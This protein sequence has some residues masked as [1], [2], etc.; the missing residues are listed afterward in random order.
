M[1]RP[2]NKVLEDPGTHNGSDKS[3]LLR[4]RKRS[5]MPYGKSIS[6]LLVDDEDEFRDTCAMW[7]TRNDHDVAEATF[8]AQL[9]LFDKL[10]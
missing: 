4:N 9:K 3:K 8:V 7:T 1:R 6:I 5:E 10:D 2:E